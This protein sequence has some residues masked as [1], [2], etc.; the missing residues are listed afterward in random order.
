MKLSSAMCALIATGAAASAQPARSV[1]RSF[2]VASV[3]PNQSGGE[4]RRAGA[5]PGGLFTATNVSLRLLISR[6]F[7]VPEYQIE[8]GPAWLD[9]ETY[10]VAARADT[11]FEMT[12]EELR[13]CLQDLLTGRFGLQWH[14]ETKAGSVYSMTVAKNG[15]KLTEHTG[16]GSASISAS[17]DSAGGEIRGLNSTMAR[18]AEYLSGQAGRPV[19][20]NTGLSGQYDFHVGWA[21]DRPADTSGPS[22]FTALQEQ[23]GL[24]LNATRGPIDIIVIDHAERASAN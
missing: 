9:T 5:S 13:P 17:T 3:K 21:L 8:R 6:A 18:L 19:I 14:K 10:D 22:I 1:P 24:K 15:P 20:D 12:R 11:S 16:P 4:G 7:G 2:E 23:L